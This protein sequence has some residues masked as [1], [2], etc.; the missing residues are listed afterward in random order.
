MW[1]LTVS[2]GADVDLALRLAG[3]AVATMVEVKRANFPFATKDF[4]QSEPGT[5]NTRK[6]AHWTYLSWYEEIKYSLSCPGR[7]IS[8]AE[9]LRKCDL[10]T[11]G[12]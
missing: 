1:V 10:N 12:H 9:N 3:T 4:I 5:Q 7:Q 11:S 6:E 2:S 8:R